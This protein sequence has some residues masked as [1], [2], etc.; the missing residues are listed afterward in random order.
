M[1][2]KQSTLLQAQLALEDTFQ[3]NQHSHQ[4]NK[5]SQNGPYPRLEDQM[6]NLKNLIKTK[7][8]TQEVELETSRAQKIELHHTHTLAHLIDK[9]EIN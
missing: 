8:T 9:A 4:Q 5:I 6:P 2:L 3:S 7:L 1:L